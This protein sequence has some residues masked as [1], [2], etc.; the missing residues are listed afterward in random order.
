[1]NQENLEF[2]QR[3]LLFMGF[4]DTMNAQL[5]AKIKEQPKDFQ[6]TMQ[7]E[8]K[9]PGAEPEKVD[10]KLDFRKSDTTD[11]YFF[12]RY[13]AKL[14][15]DLDPSKEKTQTFY[16]NKGSGVTAK[17]AFNLLQGR[18]VNK[19]LATKEGQP[20]NAWLKLDFSKKDK[21]DNFEVKQFSAGYGYDL[22]ATLKKYPIKE[23]DDSQRL[24]GLIEGIQRGNVMA[25]TF[26]REGKEDKMHIEANPQFKTL[27]LYDAD[28]KKVYQANEKKEG[29]TNGQAAEKGADMKVDKKEAVKQEGAGE[30][31]PQKK[32]KKGKGVGV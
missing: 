19:D 32:T 31:E 15:N 6:L 5:E 24:T 3:G 13:Q 4:K 20:Y 16:I 22:L 26:N 10:Y 25:V 11:M 28:M 27:V 7:G 21:H 12:N 14:L 17:E 1:M 30:D 8:Y 9:R 29:Q 23:M 18:A 2:L